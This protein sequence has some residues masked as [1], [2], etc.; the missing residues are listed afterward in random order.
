MK[1]QCSTAHSYITTQAFSPIRIWK[2]SPVFMNEDEI[3]NE[4]LCV[5]HKMQYLCEICCSA[6]ERN[7]TPRHTH[8]MVTIHFWRQG[9]QFPWFFF[10]FFYKIA[11]KVMLVL[12]QSLTMTAHDVKQMSRMFTKVTS[13]SLMRDS[14][15]TATGKKEAE[16]AVL[17]LTC[18]WCSIPML[19]VLMRIAI[20]IPRLKYLLSTMRFI[21]SLKFSQ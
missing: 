9:T 8:R 13:G 11:T 12:F 2:P 15:T 18:L 3:S 4:S 19:N 1:R 7:Q 6:L 10:F 17:A 21:L 5:H 20:I 14:R 16:G